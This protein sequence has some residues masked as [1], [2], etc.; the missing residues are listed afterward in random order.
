MKILLAGSE[1]YI[2]TVLREELIR[3]GHMVTG[4]D[5]GFY[6]E[7][8][9]TGA[10]AKP[11]FVHK[12]TRNVDTEDLRG[13]D[14]V[15]HLADLSN[16]PLGQNDPELTRDINYRGTVALARA[17][18]TVG[19]PRFIY[20][21]SCSVYGVAT[22]D[23]VD[24][25]SPVNPQT[26]YAECK[27]RSEHDI[28][29]LADGSFSPV[30]LRNATAYGVSPRMRFDLAVNNLSGWAW[31]KREVR[32]TSDGT[33]WRPFVHVRDIAQAVA[34]V[35]VAPREVV[36]GEVFNVGDDHS[37]YQ[38]R[39][40][41]KTVAEV[42]QGCSLVLGSSDGDTRSYRV[43]FKKIREKL[44]G[45]KPA[46]NIRRGA[47]EL[48]DVFARIRMTDETFTSCLYTRLKQIKYLCE[49]DQVDQN[50]FWTEK[51]NG[52]ANFCRSCGK[53]LEHTF[54]DLGSQPIANDL[55]DSEQ[56][57]RK[58]PFYPLHIYICDG[59]WLAQSPTVRREHEIFTDQYPYFSSV[60]SSWLAHAKAYVEMIISRF[61]LTNNA[62]IIEL[63]SNDGYLLQYFR[64]KG[65]PVLGIEPT[66]NTASAAIAKGIPTL[67]EF[68]GVDVA[69]KLR[70]EGATADLLIGNNV[71]AHVPDLNDFVFGMKILLRSSGIL[72]MEFPHV[73]QLIARGQFDTM[74]HEHYSYFSLLAVREVFRKHGLNVFD[75]E[76]IATHG[77]SL[78]IY[79]T[80]TE[81][82]TLREASSVNDLIEREIAFGLKNIE[83]YRQFG[84][85]VEK[86]K[87]ELL[88][89]L[90]EQK[91]RGKSIVAYG[92]AAKG[93]TLLNYCSIGT[94][95]IDYA[96]DLSPS[97]QNHLLPGSRIPIFDPAK[98][99]ETQP[100]YVLILPWNIKEEIIKDHAYV[101]EWGGQFVTAIPKV[102]LLP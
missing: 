4:L 94:N 43:S 8:W 101:R 17:A 57:S 71:L 97:K 72:T 5:T 69:E 12:D 89:F 46:W 40:V 24:E 67:S 47:E 42:F 22:T 98:L 84:E 86:T 102:E 68:F 50:L 83:T 18:K 32:L 19:V 96:V 6:A 2:G 16:D 36:H 56:E 77:G 38:I 51:T 53:K 60:S 10:G 23:V 37:N 44:P 80:H 78:R 33:P 20:S 41:A 11:K 29:E 87:A 14:A 52:S 39:D 1:G 100:D 73:L 9:F 95:L 66:R 85:S 88:R 27:I 62:R 31:T 35:L 28:L 3:R 65:F 92:A 79:A 74:Y 99:R 30:I 93:N 70:A 21:S 75:V 26:V 82:H 15:V 59:C 64:E 7:G 91:S 48:R 49:T 45:F 34:E 13:F 25:T 55:I 58:E 76:K 54:V 90:K 61:H 81:N 63:A